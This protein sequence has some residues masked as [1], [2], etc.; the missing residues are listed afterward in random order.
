M[1]MLRML[2]MLF[3]ATVL[4]PSRKVRVMQEARRRFP[5]TWGRA[6]YLESLGEIKLEARHDG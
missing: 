3:V 6:P 4:S 5:G 1:P 2:S